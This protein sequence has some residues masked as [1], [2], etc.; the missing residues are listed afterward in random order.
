MS[1]QAEISSPE[2]QEQLRKQAAEIRLKSALE[3]A[4]YIIR[5]ALAEAG[6]AGLSEAEID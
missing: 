3:K 2:Y 6:R 4:S 1:N 5:N